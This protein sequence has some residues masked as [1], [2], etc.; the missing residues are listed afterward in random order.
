MQA[1]PPCQRHKFCPNCT[2]PMEQNL[3]S[4]LPNPP[5]VRGRLAHRT[6]DRSRNTDETPNPALQTRSTVIHPHRT[7]GIQ[8]TLPSQRHTFLLAYNRAQEQTMGSPYPS[9]PPTPRGSMSYS[10]SETFRTTGSQRQQ[11]PLE[12]RHKQDHRLTAS[13]G[14]PAPNRNSK[15][16]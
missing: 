2:C 15:A 1:P 7:P 12:F 3:C 16:N 11:V 8:E 9:M 6:S 5:I 10:T 13:Q 4:I 14:I